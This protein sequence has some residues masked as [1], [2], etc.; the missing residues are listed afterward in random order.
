M[1][2]E[3]LGLVGG[4]GTGKSVLMR[5][6]LGLNRPR[7]GSIELLGADVARM[8]ADGPRRHPDALRRAVP[9]RGAVFLADA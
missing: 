4:S 7:A 8:D 6:I 2:G 3:V 1:R 9:G 5:T